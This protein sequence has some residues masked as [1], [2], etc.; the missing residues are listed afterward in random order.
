MFNIG[1]ILASIKAD[2]SGFKS[3]IASVKSDISSLGTTTGALNN[4]GKGI[5]GVAKKSVMALGVAG[6]AAG[7][8]T[9][10]S[11]SD[12]EQAKIAFG[13][14]LG[15][16]DEAGKLMVKISD[17]AAKTPFELP[18]LVET[19]KQLMAFGVSADEMIPTVKMLGNISSGTGADIGRISYAFGQVKV[20]GHLMGQDLMQFTNAG[21]PLIKLLA[22]QF[23][24]SQGEVKAL[25]SEGKVGFPEV[26]KALQSLGGEQGKWGTMMDSQSKTFGGILS[27]IKDNFGRIGREIIGIN[28]NGEIKKGG[29]FFHLKNAAQVFMTWLDENRETI[30]SVFNAIIAGIG[31]VVEVG[32]GIIGWF[33]Q[34][35]WAMVALAGAI[36]GVI[37][38]ALVIYTFTMIKAAIAT[39]A[40]IWPLLLIGAAIALLVVYWKDIVTAIK[41]AAKW[42]GDGVMSIID[43]L[44]QI[45]A[46]TIEFLGKLPY[47]I[48]HFIGWAIGSLIKLFADG[49]TGAI[50]WISKLP[51]RIANWL[52]KIPGTIVSWIGSAANKTR[53]LGKVMID[54]VVD[55]IKKLPGKVTEWF[56]KAID[57]IGKLVRKA[58]NGAKEFAKGLWN[59]FKSGL[60]IHSPSFIERALFDIEDQAKATTKN[61]SDSISELNSNAKELP[62][63]S[64][65]GLV[66]G[67]NITLVVDA[68]NRGIVAGTEVAFEEWAKT[69][70]EK[71]DR[72]FGAQGISIIGKKV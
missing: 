64:N 67:K 10:K 13:T 8:F 29:L 6:V 55:I 20:Q 66:E 19:A 68:S 49:I 39:L 31:S 14:M 15:S 44:A 4:I 43:W 9:T 52:S 18:Q 59:G 47:L 32:V 34:N 50:N 69:I 21:V 36:L 72:A 62:T 26:E 63:I 17:F 30:Q 27:N 7:V 12:F 11:A 57:A 35:Q 40:E 5:V 51:N 46:K 45:P 28:E 54:G 16:A 1:S 71:A 37:V 38:P 70:I 53:E 3:A 24:V 25:V 22:E 65:E 42:I 33:Q 61:L 60:G 58:W 48:G 56:Q 2:V 41:N 23:G